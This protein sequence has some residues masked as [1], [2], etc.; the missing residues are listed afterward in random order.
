MDTTILLA[1]LAASVTAI[2]WMINYVLTGRDERR[3]EQLDASH[4]FLQSQLEQLYGPLAFLI[5]QSRRSRQDLLAALGRDQIFVA[6]QELT[7]SERK[8]WLFWIENDIF[9]RNDKI[10]D[11]LT[12]QTH[13]IEGDR[14][15]Q[16][17][18]D[19]LDHHTSWKLSHL[20][21][22]Q[23]NVEYPLR[24]RVDYPDDFQQQV[25]DTFEKLKEKQARILGERHVKD[26]SL[27]P[28]SQA[29]PAENK[30]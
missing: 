3:K 14:V 23:D 9:P 2:G 17:Y 18:L 10:S 11:L 28:L 16:S 7:D 27:L 15:P 25:I 26:A 22:K 1:I 5:Q 13:L 30:R 24:S 8:A 20:R 29:P 19:F 4:N 12:G 21:W 6:G